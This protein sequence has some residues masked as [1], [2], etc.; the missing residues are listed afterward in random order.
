MGRNYST[1]TPEAKFKMIIYNKYINRKSTVNTPIQTVK[2]SR[3]RL[4]EENKLFLKS[5][6]LQV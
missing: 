3:P 5:L 4:T 1:T 2:T 6:N